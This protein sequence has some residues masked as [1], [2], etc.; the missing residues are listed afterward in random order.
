MCTRPPRYLDGLE[1]QA[2]AATSKADKVT[3]AIQKQ[4]VRL[5]A[6]EAEIKKLKAQIAKNADKE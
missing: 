1:R 5:S 4:T 6:A 3:M 2:K